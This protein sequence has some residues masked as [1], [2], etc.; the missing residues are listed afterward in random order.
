MTRHNR[1]IQ[2]TSAHSSQSGDRATWMAFYQNTDELVV[3]ELQR[4]LQSDV[5]AAVYLVKSLHQDRWSW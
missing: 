5:Q 4:D 1:L 3:R 2:S